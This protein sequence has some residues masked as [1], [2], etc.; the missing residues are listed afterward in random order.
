MH[1]L[2]NISLL[3]KSRLKRVNNLCGIYYYDVIEKFCTKY[4]TV[5]KAARCGLGDAKRG[6]KRNVA[7]FAGAS[8][9]LVGGGS[10]KT[11]AEGSS[12]PTIKII[13]PVRKI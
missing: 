4:V 2:N 12:P 11:M 7:V 8:S 3:S 9:K 10:D 13:F 5:R 6:E 1:L